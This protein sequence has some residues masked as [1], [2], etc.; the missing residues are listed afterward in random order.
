MDIV[1]ELL[2]KIKKAFESSVKN[3]AKVRK[4]LSRLEAGAAD[5]EDA[6]IYAEEL[7]KILSDVL[8]KYVAYDSLPDGYLYWNIADRTI[9]PMLEENYRL[10]NNTAA[11]IQK[12]I[13]RANNIGLNP[14]T[15]VNPAGRIK[16]LIDKA[17]ET[18]DLMRWLGEPVVNCSESFFDDFVVANAKF[19]YDAGLKSVIERKAEPG[20]CEWCSRLAGTYDYSELSPGDDVYR[21]HEYCRCIVTFKRSRARQDVWSK[22]KWWNVGEQSDKIET[23]KNIGLKNADTSSEIKRRIADNTYTLQLSEQK[24]AEHV[25]GTP[26]YINTAKTRG[27]EPSR[28]LI[29]KEEAQDLINAYSGHGDIDSDSKDKAKH[30]EYASANKIIGEYKNREGWIKTKRFAIYHGKKGSHI[31]PVKER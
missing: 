25:E 14:I 7:G 19:S 10:I 31:V 20:C 3:N 23:R 18:Q 8:M 12:L 28:L 24:Y 29:S 26:Q 15:G 30:V 13:D 4:A 16:G 17:V 21:R 22:E 2:G 11:D 6:H 5:L 27:Q 1:P 9:R